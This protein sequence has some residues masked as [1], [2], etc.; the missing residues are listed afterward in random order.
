MICCTDYYDHMAIP[1]I[2][3]SLLISRL[4]AAADQDAF[5]QLYQKYRFDIFRFV[6]MK[7]PTAE[8]AQDITSDVFV[9]SWIY[10]GKG[11]TVTH[12]RGLIYKIARNKIAEYY[13]SA[14]YRKVISLEELPHGLLRT[15][16]SIDEREID[17]AALVEALYALSDDHTEV[18]TLRY[19]E[20]LKVAEIAVILGKKSSATSVIL[21]RAKQALKEE[22]KKHLPASSGEQQ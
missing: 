15:T 18:L 10:I 16:I 17:T 13:R 4:N 14:E 5:A 12:F 9:Q 11:N 20:D 19:I 3:E 22:L 7:V 8:T 2:H 1:D 21:H 6:K